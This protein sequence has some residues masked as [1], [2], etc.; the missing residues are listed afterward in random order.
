MKRPYL[1]LLGIVV[2]LALV[3][4][5][6]G[7][8]PRQLPG[9]VPAASAPAPVVTVTL[10]IR[11]DSISP[12]VVRVAKGDR[13]ALVVLNAGPSGARLSLPGYEDRLEAIPLA[14]GAAWRGG[15]LADRPGDDFA[16]ILNGRPAAR[17]VVEGSH[18]VEGHR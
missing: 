6:V 18:L 5:A 4:T 7:R 13:V 12:A 15:F 14:P 17:L 1:W 16:W 8:A 10:E 11:G 9:A 2:G 3:L